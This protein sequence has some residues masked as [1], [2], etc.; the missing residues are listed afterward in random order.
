MKIFLV[1]ESYCWGYEDRGWEVKKVFFAKDAAEA[2]CFQLEVN[3]T[4]EG[5]DYYVDT[6]EVH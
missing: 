4:E 6:V 2:Y 5:L 1:C 3:N